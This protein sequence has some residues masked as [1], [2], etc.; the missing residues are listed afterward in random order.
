[1]KESRLYCNFM[2]YTT[3][4][5]E[6]MVGI[7]PSSNGRIGEVFKQNEKRLFKYYRSLDEGQFAT[8]CGVE[9]NP[10][11]EIRSWVIQQLMCNFTLNYDVFE[12]HFSECFTEY[13]DEELAV[14][15]NF[16]K[17]DF[18]EVRDDANH[19]LSVG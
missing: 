2:G 5:A 1:M 19:L 12:T 14:L 16:A 17:D 4:V 8:L 3:V 13:L 18:V 6:E 9:L 11:D 10:D 7:A 15:R